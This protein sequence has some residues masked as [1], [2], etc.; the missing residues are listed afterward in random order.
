LLGVG[1]DAALIMHREDLDGPGTHVLVI[2]IGTYD[3]L[4]G[5]RLE[6]PEVASGMQQLPAASRSAR[7]A[8]DWFLDHFHDDRRPLASLSLVLSE[9]SAARYTHERSNVPEHDLPGGDVESVAEALD[10]WVQRAAGDRR[11]LAVLYFVGHGVHAGSSIL[12]CRDYGKVK[13]RRFEWAINLDDMLVA[14]ATKSVDDQLVMVDACRNADATDQT[15][16]R[17]GRVGRNILA[18]D[19]LAQR[20]GTEAGQSIHFATSI[21]TRAWADDDGISLFSEALIQALSGGGAQLQHGW[22]VATGG[23]QEAL[24]AYVR[25]AAADVGLEQVPDRQRSA[26]FV[27]CRPRSLMVPVEVTFAPATL[28]NDQVRL[29]VEGPGAPMVF[30][31]ELAFGRRGWTLA[32]PK[33]GYTFKVT[34]EGVEAYDGSSA[35]E[36]VVPP[37]API[38]IALRLREN[39]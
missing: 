2:G 14:L 5:G 20:N 13:G 35:S 1:E 27:I 22:Q 15:L 4:I 8:A 26:D 33:G 25:R 12:L 38:D 6:N 16:S 9:P 39:E 3:Y 23:L 10:Q 32:L 21:Y 31:P 34:F 24:T 17:R 30:A 19:P 18:H 28:W 37:F 11:N 29:I 7:A 36:A